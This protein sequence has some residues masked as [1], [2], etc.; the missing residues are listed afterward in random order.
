[1][2]VILLSSDGSW[3]HNLGAAAAKALLPRV[4]RV[5]TTGGDKRH[6]LELT[7]NTLALR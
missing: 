7:D 4:D 1:M 6:L 5:F 3:S 2:K